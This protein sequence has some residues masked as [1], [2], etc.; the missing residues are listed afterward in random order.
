M[1]RT[2]SIRKGRPVRTRWRQ[3]PRLPFRRI[4]PQPEP[5]RSLGDLAAPAPEPAIRLYCDAPRPAVAVSIDWRDPPEHRTPFRPFESEG[6]LELPHP[7]PG[8]RAASDDIGLAERLRA[9]LGVPLDRLLPGEQTV[10]TW[11]APL[12]DFQVEGVRALL[13]NDRLLLADDMG[14][15]KT[16]QAIAAI[17]ILCHRRD[18]TRALLIV[19]ASLLDQ[20]TREFARW[21]PELRL[22]PIRGAFRER[23]WQWR[24][25]AHVALISYESFRADAAANR[26]TGPLR[27]MW[28]LVVID[29]AQKIKNRDTDIS[30]EV[31]R[32]RR[33]R[34]WALTGTP[35]ENQEDDLASILEFV[36]HTD[37]G[38]PR[39]Y[40]PSRALL[41]RH[42]ELQLRRKKQ[43][44][45]TQLPPK[46]I[47]TVRLP[48]QPAQRA[49]YERAERAG[50]I[51]LRQHG[52]TLRIAHILELITRLKQLCNRDPVSGESAKLADIRERLQ[53]LIAE[54]HRAL[55]FSQYTDD[56]FGVAAAARH[57]TAANPLT[58]TGALSGSARDAV[59][60]RF[61]SDPRHQALILS[62]R[63]GGAGLNLQE[64]SYV[65]HL[66][67]WWNPA[68]ERQ[69]EDRA[70]RLGQSY[71]VT[72]IKYTC[73]DTIEERIERV[74]AHKQ[75]LFDE[76]VDDV[77]LDLAARLTRDDLFGLFGLAAPDPRRAQTRTST[78]EPLIAR[79]AS[80]LERRGWT[81]VP[82]APG[83]SSDREQE[84]LATKIDEVGLARTLLVR[85]REAPRPLDTGELEAL[86]AGIPEAQRLIVAAPAGLTPQAAALAHQ[87]QIGIWDEALLTQFEQVDAPSEV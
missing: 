65:F 38:A 42:Q 64:A 12:M 11:P 36:D 17:R 73:L 79:C 81:I 19:P 14:L 5:P 43:D 25:D 15:G 61:K 47:I 72:V 23:S 31:K 86:A 37:H 68:V 56:R 34:S 50:I 54:G 46:Q 58:Y 29:E 20:W 60:Q 21:A 41:Q 80:I 35:L 32:L 51:Q 16:V 77:S 6:L 66:D 83:R 57:L 45:L 1:K 44:V 69:A 74:L 52:E 63:A 49:A 4:R 10:L 39:I 9:L 70:H 85:C 40:A 3:G 59:I 22:I 55:L 30:R 27:R 67:R 33:R 18:V 75:H 53:T 7:A 71:P 82:A 76:I 26:S 2:V 78:S 48:L 24:T 87:R 84:L 28:D 13:G 62:L 8:D